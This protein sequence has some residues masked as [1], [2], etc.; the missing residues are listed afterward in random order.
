MEAEGGRPAALMLLCGVLGTFV[1]CVVPKLPAMPKAALGA[2]RTTTAMPAA[3][4]SLVMRR[5]DLRPVA[6]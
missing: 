4:D 6:A 5:R 3:Q 1:P 2:P